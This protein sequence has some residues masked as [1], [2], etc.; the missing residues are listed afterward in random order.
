MKTVANKVEWVLL[1]RKAG[2]LTSASNATFLCL[3][4][5]NT[6]ERENCQ[7]KFRHL[8]IMEDNNQ[9]HNLFFFKSEKNLAWYHDI[10]SENSVNIYSISFIIVS[11]RK[12]FLM[13]K[14]ANVMLKAPR[15]SPCI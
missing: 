5:S 10:M 7:A 6:G 12:R 9:L 13:L 14:L 4:I 8:D 2:K 1:E 15:T 3:I 11:K